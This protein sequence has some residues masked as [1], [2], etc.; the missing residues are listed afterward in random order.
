MRFNTLIVKDPR[1]VD[2]NIYNLN[3]CMPEYSFSRPISLKNICIV[4]DLEDLEIFEDLFYY[5]YYLFY[6]RGNICVIHPGLNTGWMKC[7][8]RNL[9]SL[10]PLNFNK[11]PTIDII[12]C[13]EAAIDE[14]ECHV[15][16]ISDKQNNIRGCKV[17]TI[18]RCNPKYNYDLSVSSGGVF[19]WCQNW[20]LEYTMTSF[21]K[22]LS[23]IYGTIFEGMAIQFNKP[24]YIFG[25]YLEKNTPYNI[26]DIGN[27]VDIYIET[28]Y[29]DIEFELFGDN[30]VE[31][32]FISC[33]TNLIENEK[34]YIAPFNMNPERDDGESYNRLF[35]R[36][37]QKDNISSYQVSEYEND[38]GFTLVGNFYRGV[39]SKL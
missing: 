14:K 13:L 35:G 31:D 27:D 33:T 19:V 2:K 18:A 36:L 9:N 20:N 32:M 29:D 28:D 26:G 25:S 3:I 34:A 5:V 39:Y 30:V 15:I 37:K 24:T 4:L 38:F 8:N 1:V 6:K 21:V 16:L 17:H 22:I 10:L 23:D 11:D 7:S 12:E